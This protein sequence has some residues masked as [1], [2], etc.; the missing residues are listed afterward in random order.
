MVALLMPARRRLRFY[1]PYVIVLAA[2]G[3]AIYGLD[4][5]WGREVYYYRA[6][7]APFAA[8]PN[9]YTRETLLHPLVI[10]LLHLNVSPITYSTF[11]LFWWIATLCYLGVTIEAE[12]GRAQTALIVG[13]LVMH[14]VAMILYTWT[15]MPDY[16]TVFFTAILCFTNQATVAGVIAFL[17]ATNHLTLM[18]VI[19]PLVGVV[20][21]LIGR[22]VMWPI[23]LAEALGLLLGKAVI[24]LYLMKAG[25]YPL[26]GRIQYAFDNGV[27]IARRS[28]AH[29]WGLLWSL[30]LSFWLIMAMMIVVII[31]RRSDWR[32][33]IAIIIT[34]LWSIAVTLPAEDTTRIYALV[35]WGP[36]L[37]VIVRVFT[38]LGGTSTARRLV[39]FAYATICLV[40]LCLPIVFSWGG[41]LLGMEDTRALL[42]TTIT[43]RQANK[44]G[45]VGPP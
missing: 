4:L 17:A 20:R 11:G 8:E 7:L 21:W 35:S 36:I 12:L 26:S 27:D 3:L 43:H 28:L 34:I 15:G 29:P 44:G 39:S 22:A 19:V 45:L 16:F 13:S 37:L 10:W 24:V 1:L 14:P 31:A 18:L 41:N 9:S 42:W 30:N 2:C 33:L 38:S 23:V 5:R 40:G 6:S 25:I 32:A